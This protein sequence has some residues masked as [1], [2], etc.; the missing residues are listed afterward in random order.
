MNGAG[1]HFH[2]LNAY[3]RQYDATALSS[4]FK[5]KIL[6]KIWFLWSL[7]RVRDYNHLV[8]DFT[9]A[10][11][12]ILKLVG[13]KF[14]TLNITPY[15]C[16]SPKRLDFI[17]IS[18]KEGARLISHTREGVDFFKNLNISVEEEASPAINLVDLF[19]HPMPCNGPFILCLAR[20][21]SAQKISDYFRSSPVGLNVVVLGKFDEVRSFDGLVFMGLIS[22]IFLQYLI[23]NARRIIVLH[24]PNFMGESAFL[25]HVQAL[26][27]KSEYYK[28]PS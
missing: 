19:G 1:H 7:I 5:S 8:L 11:I 27:R 13:S 12:L 9:D 4:N 18:F 2:S 16:M 14:R 20:H 23:L 15:P 25:G 28:L 24:P 22:E 26:G 6:R 3:V 21:V 17:R 10:D